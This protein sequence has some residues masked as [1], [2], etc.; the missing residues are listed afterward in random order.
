MAPNPEARPGI[1]PALILGLALMECLALYAL[2]IILA[3][4]V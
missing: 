1:Q 2:V 4:A 3:K